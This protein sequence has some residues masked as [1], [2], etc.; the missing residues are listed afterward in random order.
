MQNHPN[1]R[2]PR[3]PQ[4]D[5]ASPGAYL[6]TICTQYRD[7]RFGEVKNGTMVLSDAGAMV[8]QIWAAHAISNSGYEIGQFIVMP[9][10]VHG[11]VHVGANPGVRPIALDRFIGAFKS[12]TT[13]EYIKG[14]KDGRFPPFDK[15]L[16]QRSFHDRGL[17]TDRDVEA[18]IQYIECNPERWQQTRNSP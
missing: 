1:R 17:R 18:A 12:R 16:W 11:I 4:F 9:D 8:S 2:S 6:I 14:V 10:H 5:Y 15:Q 7:A 3:I 13:V